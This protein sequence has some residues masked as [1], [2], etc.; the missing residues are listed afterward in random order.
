MQVIFKE[1]WANTPL[2]P[3]CCPLLPPPVPFLQN[4]SKNKISPV[5]TGRSLAVAYGTYFAYN[6]CGQ[7][8]SSEIASGRS[9][10]KKG[11]QK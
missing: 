9:K 3:T 1:K 11:Y 7:T 6:G 5:E 10:D 4:P 8:T 2:I